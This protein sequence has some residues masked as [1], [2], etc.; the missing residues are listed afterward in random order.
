MDAVSNT[1][2]V[3]WEANGLSLH[4]EGWS[5]RT[6]GG[7]RSAPPG[8]RGDDRQVPFSRGL[9]RVRKTRDARVM[10]LGMWI[11][12]RDADGDRYPGLTDEQAMHG[13]WRMLV[14]AL[15]VDGTFPLVKRFWIGSTVKVVTATAELLDA[16]EPTVSGGRR[17]ETSLSVLLADPYFYE[18]FAAQAIGALSVGGD[19]PT[20]HLIVTLNGGTNPRVTAPDGNWVQYNGSPGGTPVVVDMLNGSATRGGQ[21]VN[22]LISRNRSFAEWMTLK[23]G[24]GLT[25]SGGGTATVAYDAAWR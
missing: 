25:L 8:K 15:D 4:T 16:P 18:A 14:N 9:R 3:Y 6:F 22:G 7:S 5:L 19:S 12:P 2:P 23:P 17:M 10:A 20:D 11:L 1:T 24:Q 21:Y 13:N